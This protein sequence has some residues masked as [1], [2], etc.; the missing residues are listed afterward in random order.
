MA[1]ARLRAA[2]RWSVDGTGVSSV[3]RTYLIARDSLPTGADTEEVDAFDGL[4]ALGT[5]HA[6][7]P[8]LAV[9]GYEFEEGDGAEKQMVK[10]T[11]RYSQIQRS[12]ESAGSG[13]TD[14][15]E[16]WGWSSGSVARD[17][18]HDVETGVAV[19]NSAGDP[20]D[21]VP[22]VDRPLLT[23]RKTI[24][25]KGR[26]NWQQHIGCVNAS[27]VTIGG[28]TCAARTIKVDGVDEERIFGDAYGWKY[29]YTISMQYLSNKVKVG[30]ASE[31][32]EIGWDI[33]FVDQG[34]R[35]ISDGE[36]FRFTD[37]DEEGNEVPSSLPVLMDG[38]GQRLSNAQTDEPFVIVAHA[39][40]TTNIPT[41]FYS[42]PAD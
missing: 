36:P 22:Q 28:M 34:L 38:G 5:V 41:D 2:R 12:S 6:V 3:T 21:S 33:A 35:G 30:G 29:R 9:S 16:E 25:T 27:A 39:Y 1:T 37:K 42:E 23:F 26:K 4:P 11:V 31:L 8:N 40:P 32:S 7:N 19:L 13:V 20:F 17:L 18:T 14:A 10:V 24:K 15:V